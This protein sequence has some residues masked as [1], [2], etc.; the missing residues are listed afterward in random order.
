ME[1]GIIV[2]SIADDTTAEAMKGPMPNPYRTGGWVVVTR[3]FVERVFA[4]GRER[5][6]ALSH[7]FLF[8]TDAAWN[9]LD[10]PRS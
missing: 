5:E 10:L 8:I 3:H 4:E 6:F 2:M 7:K 9:K 1:V